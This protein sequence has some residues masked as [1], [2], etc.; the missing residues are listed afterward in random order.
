MS[1][2]YSK[3]PEYH[4]ELG[5]QLAALRRKGVLIIGSGNLVHNLRR[6]AWDKLDTAGFAYD[7]ATEAQTK[8]NNWL[9]EGNHRALMDYKNQGQAFQLAIPTPEHYHPLMYILG[10]QE[11]KDELTLFNDK[12][13]GGSLTMT[14]VFLHRS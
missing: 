11:S 4:Y 2:D 8:M 10:L 12:P 14:S 3:G 6:I 1:M 7:W 5:K 13:V 9:Q